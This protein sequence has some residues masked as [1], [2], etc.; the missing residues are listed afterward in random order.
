V[1]SGDYGYA[2]YSPDAYKYQNEMTMTQTVATAQMLGQRFSQAAPF[3]MVITAPPENGAFKTDFYNLIVA[4]CRGAPAAKCSIEPAPDPTEIDT[5]IPKPQFAGIVI[6]H[7]PKDSADIIINIIMQTLDCFMMHKSES[8]PDRIARLNDAN[9]PNFYWFEIGRGS[10]WKKEEFA[11][12]FRVF[13]PRLLGSDGG[14]P[15][16]FQ[17][18]RSAE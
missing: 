3:L 13:L 4:A 8:I 11:E 1:G 18:A 10:P 7:R 9:N 16:R 12:R 15:A 6:H 5:G 17:S 14:D 2:D